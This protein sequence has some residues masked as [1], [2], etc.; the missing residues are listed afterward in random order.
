MGFDTSTGALKWKHA[1][2]PWY[3]LGFALDEERAYLYAKGEHAMGICG[4][5]HWG[6]IVTDQDGKVYAGRG[7]GQLYIF[8]PASNTETKFHTGDGMLMNGVTFAPGLMVVPTCSW[9][10][11][12]R[13]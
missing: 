10:Y 9:V 5:P 13:F 7:D 2:E 8:D 6:G 3:G 1:V 4:P 12:F 11:V